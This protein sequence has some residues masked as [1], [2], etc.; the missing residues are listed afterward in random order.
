MRDNRVLGANI[1][2]SDYEKV[3]SYIDLY[4]SKTNN[5]NDSVSKFIWDCI[6]F[7]INYLRNHDNIK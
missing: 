1:K 3:I 7:R 2:T 4:N 6:K 5:N